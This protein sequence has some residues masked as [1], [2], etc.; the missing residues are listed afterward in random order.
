MFFVHHNDIHGRVVNLGHRKGS[1]G[2]GEVALDRFK[3]LRRSF[4][5][6]ALLQLKS[7]RKHSDAAPHGAGIG[8]FEFGFKALQRDLFNHSADGWL[9]RSEVDRVNRGFNNCLNF[10]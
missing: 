3:L 5:V 2:T 7:I 4:L 6:L 9:F 10:V 8:C 1:I